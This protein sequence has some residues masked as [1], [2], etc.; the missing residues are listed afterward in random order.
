MF[1]GFLQTRIRTMLASAPLAS[2]GLRRALVAL[3]TS[4]GYAL[5]HIPNG[6]LIALAFA[7][8][9]CWS[10]IFYARPNV[11]L[12]G[13]CHAILGT[14][15][16]NVVM[17]YT[18]IGPFYAEPQRHAFVSAFPGLKALIGNLM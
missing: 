3:L 18:R 7:V 1:F 2:E 6:P 15:L 13:T 11:L 9:L 5:S 4:S 17:M 10:W 16:Q 14:I 8:G 12:L